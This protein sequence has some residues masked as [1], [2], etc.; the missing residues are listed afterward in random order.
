[1]TLPQGRDVIAHTLDA[2]EHY[3]DIDFPLND[4]S[5]VRACSC[6]TRRDVSKVK[7]HRN[8]PQV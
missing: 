5:N 6:R 8:E 2:N 1:L 7:T 3:A 4:A